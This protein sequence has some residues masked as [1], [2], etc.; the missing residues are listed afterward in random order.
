MH[1]E[2]EVDTSALSRASCPEDSPAA[3]DIREAFEDNLGASD[4]QAA[5]GGNLGAWDIQVASE[6][7]LGASDT[8]AASGGNLEDSTQLAVA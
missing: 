3:W 4:T 7:N 5:S 2:P 1:Q 8:Q 6:D